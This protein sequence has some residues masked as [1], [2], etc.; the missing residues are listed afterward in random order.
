MVPEVVICVVTA[1]GTECKKKPAHA[2]PGGSD[3]GYQV[4][5]AHVS[6][7]HVIASTS[8]TQAQLETFLEKHRPQWDQ[9][10]S[11][12]TLARTI[13]TVARTFGLDPRVF[14]ALVSQESRFDSKAVSFRGALGLTQLTVPGIEEFLYQTGTAVGRRAPAPGAPWMLATV[15][16][17]LPAYDG[18]DFLFRSGQQRQ[19]Y[20]QK[21]KDWA[22]KS[23]L[24][25]LTI[26]A[27]ILKTYV[28]QSCQAHPK[29]K[30]D[31]FGSAAPE[32]VKIKWDV[33]ETALRRY[34]GDEPAIREEYAQKVLRW[35][36]EL[37]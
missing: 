30:T 32:A 15:R 7:R 20:A 34:N 23:E 22:E 5:L 16:K 28:A 17:L 11:R 29:C 12:S 2:T 26:G 13:L 3:S 19:L 4:S 10:L 14:V 21:F 9:R 35:A 18:S 8:P 6:Q 24:V 33:Y 36:R 31:T 27:T 25:Q 1:M 37:N